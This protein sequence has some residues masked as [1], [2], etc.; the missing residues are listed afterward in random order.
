MVEITIDKELVKK[1]A[2]NARLELTEKEL[3][4]FTPQLKEI[5]LDSFNKLDEI[6]VD[7]EPSFQPIE[8]KNKFRKDK[9]KKPLSQEKA[10]ENVSEKL[11]EKGYIKG[12]KPMWR[13]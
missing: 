12:P 9:P 6:S 8:Q 7:E 5:I 1:V 11:K 10:L 13:D 4:K 2:K 3:E